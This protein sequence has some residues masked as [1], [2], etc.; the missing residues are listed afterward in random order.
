MPQSRPKRR[1]YLTASGELASPVKDVDI[2]RARSL[3][4]VEVLHVY[5]IVFH[6]K[7][8][9]RKAALVER[10]PSYLR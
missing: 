5:H 2:Q 6:E 9:R 1:G 4:I 3:G 8:L 7:F 10:V